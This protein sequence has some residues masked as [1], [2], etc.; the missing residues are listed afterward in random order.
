MS[1]EASSEQSCVHEEVGYDKVYL[2]SQGDPGTSYPKRVSSTNLSSEEE[3]KDLDVDWSKSSSNEDSDE[4]SIENVDSSVRSVVGPDG[5]K[6]F[7]LPFI[8]TVNDLTQPLINVMRHH[9]S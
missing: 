6:N 5:L 1:S 3:E 4:E 8:W 7:V 9:E 2:L